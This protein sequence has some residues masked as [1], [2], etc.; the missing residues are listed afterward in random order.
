MFLKNSMKLI[1]YINFASLLV[2]IAALAACGSHTYHVVKP[3]ETLYSIGWAYGIDYRQI[4]DWNDIDAPY[5]INNGQKIRLTAL[6]GGKNTNQ[7]RI[8]ETDPG[9]S[10]Q[11]NSGSDKKPA[12]ETKT[13]KKL[14]RA[15]KN[16]SKKIAWKWPTISKNVVQYFSRRG[17][18]NTAYIHKG[19][20]EVNYSGVNN[21]LDIAGRRG[22][23]IRAAAAGQ[24]VYSG[25]GLI[26]YGK[27][28]II[29]HDDSF[30]SAYAHNNELLVKEG[31]EITAGQKIATMGSS[32]TN[33]VILH[34]EIRR[35]GQPVN[36][37]D[38]LPVAG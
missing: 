3:G 10:L 14:A 6:S 23:T 24:V 8:F 36:P 35:D 30:L 28:I 38:Y 32:G 4:A 25:S 1:R 27:L 18:K 15:N 13:S 11:K 7:S 22:S 33:R 5:G 9:G 20:D 16:Q 31:D 17:S 26:G 12:K 19:G 21:G 37:L 2:F 34:F 29:K